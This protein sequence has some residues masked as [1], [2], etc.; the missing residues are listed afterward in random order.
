MSK[1]RD[2]Y[3]ENLRYKDRNNSK[4]EHYNYAN[5]CIDLRNSEIQKEIK[6]SNL[7]LIG[8]YAICETEDHQGLRVECSSL[9]VNDNLDVIPRFYH[10]KFNFRFFES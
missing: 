6:V 3:L 8:R 1:L 5:T 7:F 9:D 4:I 10:G 2:E